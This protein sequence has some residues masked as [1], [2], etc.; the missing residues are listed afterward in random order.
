[1]SARAD[2]EDDGADLF[3]VIAHLGVTGFDG[4]GNATG[5]LIDFA[6]GVTGFDL[7]FGDHTDAEF[8]GEV[9]GATV[10]ENRSRGR[11]YARV[12]I[13]ANRKGQVFG[14]S[15]EF[16][17][18]VSA[19]VTPDPAVVAFLDPLREELSARLGVVVGQSTV[20]IPRSDECGQ[21]AGRTCESLVGDVVAD[22]MRTR[23][24]TDFALMNSGGLR[25]NLTCPDPDLADDV[26]PAPPDA[27]LRFLACASRMTSVSQPEAE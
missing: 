8:S 12:T 17:D 21:S 27:S 15:V 20:A 26:C 3:V 16:V 11:T 14:K 25:A 23:Y 5:P 10:V 9:N 7:I 19:D 24:G 4:D 18:P 1:M 13:T 22:A 2:A 6:N